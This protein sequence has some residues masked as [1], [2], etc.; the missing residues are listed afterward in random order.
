MISAILYGRNDNYGYNLH[1]RAA[2]SLNC[3]AEMLDAPD[4]EILFVDY[5]TPDDF[6][7]FPE[8]IRDT[9]TDRAKGILRILRVRPAQHRRFAGKSH[10]VALEPVARNV[11]IRRSNPANRWLFSTNTDMVFVPRRG[12][13]LSAI[14]AP[15][16][17]GYYH[18][19]RC[20]LPESLWETLDRYDARGT[21]EQIGAWGQQLHLNELMTHELPYLRFDGPGDFQ[22]ALRSDV[23][24]IWGFDE[25]MLLGFH[26]DSNFAARLYQLYHVCG[27]VQDELFGYHCDHTRQVTP[28]HRHNAVEN[29]YREYVF[30]IKDAYDAREQAETWGLADAEVEEVR[31][32]GHHFPYLAAL[33]AAITEPMTQPTCTELGDASI[34]RVDY[35]PR[36]ALPFLLDAFVEYPRG[37]VLGWF[38]TRADTL[39]M[40]ARAWH[41]AGFT[42][43]ILVPDDA[44]WLGEVLPPGVERRRGRAIVSSAHVFVLDGGR[45]AGH[46]PE[47]SWA[48]SA[49]MDHVRRALGWIVTSE[50]RAAA[51]RD[52]PASCAALPPH[53]QAPRR[54]VGLNCLMNRWQQEFVG[55]IGAA[56]SPGSTRVRQGFVLPG[57]VGGVGQLLNLASLQPASGGMREG[58]GIRLLTNHLGVV[59]IST[60]V[61]LPA[62]KWRL[63]LDYAP[64]RRPLPRPGPLKLRA[65]VGDVTI[66]TAY[67]V[68]TGLWRQK[69]SFDFALPGDPNREEDEA[70]V[71]LRMYTVGVPAGILTGARLVPRGRARMRVQ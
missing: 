54:V 36:H 30:G 64:K 6:P 11:A 33:S 24:R 55:V 57:P 67:K 9:L 61:G 21:I 52:E 65:L 34:E 35:D 60:V 49:P 10:L 17:D 70:V 56:K 13:T 58:E 12:K 25:R 16:A 44:P 4:D 26:V 53:L 29:N 59:F 68:V 20:E 14:A 71:Q 45:P 22:L 46:D 23:H 8:A 41:E 3:I 43:V 39:A 42:G 62:G 40:F 27:D 2:L 38:G 7:T 5:N 32:D 69:L 51:S 66:A 1:K 18:L 28:A 15:L 19:A 48:R 50:R 47:T 37:T 63:E 31:L